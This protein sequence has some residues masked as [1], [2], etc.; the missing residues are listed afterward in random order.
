[1]FYKNFLEISFIF[2]NSAIKKIVRNYFYF[3]INLKKK[4]KKDIL[5]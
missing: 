5:L 1:M 2:D 3:I 4:K